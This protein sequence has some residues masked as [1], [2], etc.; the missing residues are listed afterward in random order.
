MSLQDRLRSDRFRLS[1][2]GWVALSL[3]ILAFLLHAASW[4][5][6]PFTL[7]FVSLP[8]LV[9]LAVVLAYA[10]RADDRVLLHRLKHGFWAGL[11][12]TLVFYDGGRVLIQASGIWEY[13]AFRAMPIF[14]SLITERP[15][16]AAASVIAGWIYHFWNGI[17]FGMMYALMAAGRHW[18]WGFAWAMFLEMAMIY[19]YPVVFGVSRTNSGF[20]II[21]ILGHALYGIVLGVWMQRVGAEP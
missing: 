7:S 15:P 4:V 1:L 17:S 14:G 10:R 19:T 5:R 18:F 3:G 21:S 16:A 6:M 2:I 11:I 13:D 9:V 20:V 12:G 8:G